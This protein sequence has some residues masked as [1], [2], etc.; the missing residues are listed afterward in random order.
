MPSVD[1]E[2]DQ[3]MTDVANG[4][5]V[6]G[7]RQD[8][9]PVDVYSELNNTRIRMVRHGYILAWIICSRVSSF[10]APVT[11]LHPSSLKMR[12]TPSAMRSGT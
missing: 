4:V 7:D 6:D 1:T 2:E 8:A 9:E 5:I 12:I 10:L 3:P 11:H